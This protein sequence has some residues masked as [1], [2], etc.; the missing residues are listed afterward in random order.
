[1]SVAAGQPEHQLR[2]DLMEGVVGGGAN[3]PSEPLGRYRSHRLA[4]GPAGPSEAAV[5]GNRD[6]VRE[7]AFA[8]G[9][10]DDDGLRIGRE[11]NRPAETTMHGRVP[12]CSLATVGSRATDQICP[13]LLARVEFRPLLRG[14]RVR[15]ASEEDSRITHLCGNLHRTAPSGTQSDVFA[16]TGSFL[17]AR[18]CSAGPSATAQRSKSPRPGGKIPNPKT[19]TLATDLF[20]QRARVHVTVPARCRRRLTR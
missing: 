2:G 9:Q 1:M 6:V 16:V 7:S 3:L 13:R 5:V 15:L 19:T 4:H 11:L 14:C 20:R 12:R 17:R 8:A 10:W 18:R